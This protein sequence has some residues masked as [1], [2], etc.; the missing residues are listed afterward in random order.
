MS[1]PYE[2]PDDD[3]VDAA[4]RMPTLVWDPKTGSLTEKPGTPKRDP[5]PPAT[6]R[7]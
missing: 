1:D 3:M 6:P 7:R 5:E 4:D 2:K